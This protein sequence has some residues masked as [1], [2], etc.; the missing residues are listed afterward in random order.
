[1]STETYESFYGCKLSWRESLLCYV[2]SA[3]YPEFYPQKNEAV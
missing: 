1:M 3:A 2:R